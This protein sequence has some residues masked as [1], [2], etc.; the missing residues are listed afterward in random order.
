MA[1]KPVGDTVAVKFVELDEEE[2]EAARAAWESPLPLKEEERDP[3]LAVILGVG[4]EVTRKGF[5]KGDT[6]LLRPYAVNSTEL[7]DGVYAVDAW[8]VM[9]VVTD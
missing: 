3:V 8:S 7:S 2:L 4:T 6:V 5:K 1:I 9:A